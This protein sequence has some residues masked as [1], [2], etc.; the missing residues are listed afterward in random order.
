MTS[1]AFEHFLARLYVD[2]DTRAQFLVA[3]QATARSAGLN[4]EECAAL[5]TI[6]AEGLRLAA[7]S[8]ERKRMHICMGSSRRWWYQRLVTWLVT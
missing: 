5:V 1:S 4:D 2:A 6:D 8:F 3:P 7:T